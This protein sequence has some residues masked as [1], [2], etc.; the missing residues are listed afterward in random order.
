MN[1]EELYKANADLI[2]AQAI[3][4]D[5]FEFISLVATPIRSDGTFNNC[6]EALQVKAQALLAKH[7][8]I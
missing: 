1:M 7:K 8:Y 6:R 4:A 5:F 2:K 3:I